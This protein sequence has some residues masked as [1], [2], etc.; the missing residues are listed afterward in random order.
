MSFTH[1]KMFS[2]LR[3]TRSQRTAPSDTSVAAPLCRHAL[4]AEVLEGFPVNARQR[5]VM[6]LE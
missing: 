4:L 5:L 1:G 2:D 3:R 6:S